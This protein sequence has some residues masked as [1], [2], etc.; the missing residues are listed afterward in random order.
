MQVTDMI[1]FDLFPF[2]GAENCENRLTFD[3][4][5]TNYVMSC[6]LWTTAT[7]S[8]Q[9]TFWLCPWVLKV[10]DAIKIAAKGSVSKKTLKNTGIHN[11]E[12]VQVC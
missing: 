7:P 8:P 2:N 9:T 10:P 6:F 11:T 5:V 12:R 1:I 3:K 4:V